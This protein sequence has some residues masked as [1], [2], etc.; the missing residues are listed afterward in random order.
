MTA[1]EM[2]DRNR[3]SIKHKIANTIPEINENVKDLLEE[4]S[5]DK[6]LDVG[7]NVYDML[8]DV[9]ELNAKCEALLEKS[10]KQ[11]EY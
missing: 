7:S 10:R 2:A 9:D 8:R 1:T 3:D 4:L 5:V 6:Y 11:Q